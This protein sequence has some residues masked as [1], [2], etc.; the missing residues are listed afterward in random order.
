MFSKAI[1][2]TVLLSAL[3]AVQAQTFTK[4]NPTKTSMPPPPIANQQPET[5]SLANNHIACPDDDA[6][7]GVQVTDFSKESADWFALEGTTIDYNGGANFVI[8]KKLQAPTIQSHKHIMFGS[9][10][11]VMKQ[12][13]G[14][15]IVSSFI[16]ES[17][18]LDEIDWEWLG[19]K[20]NE[21][22]SNFFGKGDTT[23]Y[24][25]GQTHTGQ[26]NTITEYL[27]YTIEW[28]HKSIQWSVGEPGKE[29]KVLRTTTFDDPLTHGGSRY[30][31]TPM[32]VKIGNWIACPDATDVK[33]AGTCEWAG[34]QFNPASGPYTMS[35]K[36]VTVRDYGCGNSGTPYKYGDKSGSW[37][38]IT[39]KGYCAG[40]LKNQA[41]VAA[42]P[43]QTTKN[44]G[45]FAESSTVSS[46]TSSATGTSATKDS[47]SAQTTATSGT[48]TLATVSPTKASS[49]TPAPAEISKSAA[50]KPKHKMGA[51]DIGVIALGLGLGYLVM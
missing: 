12:S 4:C 38:S 8:S 43:S 50:M 1:S 6:L 48:S 24:D 5:P 28:T 39:P 42:S 37:E 3:S 11:A 46:A 27:N 30:P 44:G 29:S 16:L 34:G 19:S 31:Q 51:L 9:V 49:A 10:S 23:T 14:A 20:P 17:D 15:G 41:A 36:S 32:K 33:L 45:V 40:P 7:G 47:S 26:P 21:V 25:R 13:P 35:V 18:D 2:A 22:Q